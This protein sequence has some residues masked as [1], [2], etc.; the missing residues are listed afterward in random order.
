MD[1][2]LLGDRLL[3]KKGS[4]HTAIQKK[5]L[6]MRH[7]CSY[8]PLPVDVLVLWHLNMSWERYQYVYISCSSSQ[9]VEKSTPQSTQ[10]SIFLEK[11]RSHEIIKGKWVR[12]NKRWEWV[13]RKCQQCVILDMVLKEQSCQRKSPVRRAGCQAVCLFMPTDTVVDW[14]TCGHTLS[15][16]CRLTERQRARRAKWKTVR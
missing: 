14:L 6:Q 12:R 8:L 4:S 1:N 11:N 13:W 15:D 2:L 5:A 3:L 7:C 9:D 16:R 10:T